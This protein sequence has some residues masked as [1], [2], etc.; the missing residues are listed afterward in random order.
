MKPIV[1]LI[2]DFDGTLSPG[3]M[4]EYG[5]IQA[6]GKTPA[7]FWEK[8]NRITIDQDMSPILAYMRLIVEEAAARNMP[9]KLSTLRE[10]GSQI[11]LYPGVLEWFSLINEYGASKGIV[12][13]HYINSSGITEMIEGSPIA[14]EFKK[15]FASSFYYDHEGSAVWPAVAVDYTAKTQFLFKITKGIMEVA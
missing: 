8:T 3:N 15:I 6:F 2:Y 10:Y 9:L 13:E 11:E 7:E 14:H 5:F 4:Q 12:I 1:A